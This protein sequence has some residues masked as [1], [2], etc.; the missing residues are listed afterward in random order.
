MSFVL[1]H[2]WRSVEFDSPQDTIQYTFV[3][4]KLQDLEL[5]KSASLQNEGV[6]PPQ[7]NRCGASKADLISHGKGTLGT[8]KE[9][10]TWVDPPD[11]TAEEEAN[12]TV[13]REEESDW[14]L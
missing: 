5:F 8:P 4:S 1:L 6:P 14:Y 10:G 3:Y 7:P 2:T 12:C 13:T 11:G 9:S